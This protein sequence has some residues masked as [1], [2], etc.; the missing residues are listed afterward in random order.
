MWNYKRGESDRRD[1]N[2]VLERETLGT[3]GRK[4]KRKR[5]NPPMKG[6]ARCCK[7]G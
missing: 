1:R 4:M 5:E 3:D 6:I 7:E 2:W